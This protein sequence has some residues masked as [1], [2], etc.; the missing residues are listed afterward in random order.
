MFYS[1]RVKDE[2]GVAVMLR[3]YTVKN[4]TKVECYSDRLMFVKISA[5]QLIL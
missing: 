5:N 3:N 1:G 2:K 4:V